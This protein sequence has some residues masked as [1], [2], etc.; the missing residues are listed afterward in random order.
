MQKNKNTD[1]CEDNIQMQK[2]NNIDKCEGYY[3]T[4]YPRSNVKTNYKSKKIRSGGSTTCNCGC[5]LK[6]ILR[7]PNAQP[8]H[9][10]PSYGS[11]LKNITV[12]N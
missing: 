2:N 3:K 11:P 9:Q 6:C 7:V 1:K 4:G 8:H 10:I 5:D 12:S